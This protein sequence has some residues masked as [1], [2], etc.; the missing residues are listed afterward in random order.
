MQKYLV[1]DDMSTSKF[2][3]EYVQHEYE[4]ERAFTTIHG[5]PTLVWIINAMW[6]CYLAK[7]TFD[8]QDVVALSIPPNM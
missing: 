7:G 5:I 4:L 1:I 2:W 3:H 8:D 6:K